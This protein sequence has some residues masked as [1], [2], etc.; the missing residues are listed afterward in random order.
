MGAMRVPAWVAACLL[1]LMGL[2]AGAPEDLVSACMRK[3][4]PMR[5]ESYRKT[6]YAE[7]DAFLA[8]E[9]TELGKAFGVEPFLMLLQTGDDPDVFAALSRSRTRLPGTVA[10]GLPLVRDKLWKWTEAREAAVA[11]F[12]AH[13]HAHIAQFTQKGRLSGRDKE[14]HADA[15]AGWYVGQRKFAGLDDP[16]AF[17]AKLFTYGHPEFRDPATHGSLEERV[18]AFVAGYAQRDGVLAAV[19]PLPD[20]DPAPDPEPVPE[21]AAEPVKRPEAAP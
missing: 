2:S 10:Y 1:C 8:H 12:L 6:G 17:A 3:K 18:A 16:A 15:L 5:S 9:R 19:F 11:A 14:L 21:P 13:G 20:R 7:L 4:T